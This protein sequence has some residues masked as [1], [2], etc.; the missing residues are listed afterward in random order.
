MQIQ[1]DFI[2]KLCADARKAAGIAKWKHNALRHS[3]AS[4]HMAAFENAASTALELGHHDSRVTFEH[5]R[6]LV[7]PADAQLYWQIVPAKPENVI[8]IS[9]S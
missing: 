9:A 5:Y 6:E 3:F 2:A 7:K 4:Y 1:E 8:A